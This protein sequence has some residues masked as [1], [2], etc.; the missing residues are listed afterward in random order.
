MFS[1][2]SCL[3]LVWLGFGGLGLATWS[4]ESVCL[5]VCLVN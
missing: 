4:L 1:F 5:S 3:G 2:S